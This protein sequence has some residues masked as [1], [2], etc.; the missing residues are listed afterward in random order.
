MNIGS[1]NFRPSEVY[2]ELKRT[3]KAATSFCWQ[4]NEVFEL[5]FKD[6]FEPRHTEIKPLR[7]I[8]KKNRVTMSVKNTAIIDK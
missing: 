8:L 5:I 1:N 3:K 4:S 2:D 6:S 7:S